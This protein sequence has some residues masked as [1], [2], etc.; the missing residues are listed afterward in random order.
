[1]I[2]VGIQDRKLTERLQLDPELTLAKAI[3]RAWQNETVKKQQP[4]LHRGPSEEP[5][6]NN[7]DAIGLRGKRGQKYQKG[8][9][10]H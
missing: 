9:S 6:V 1:M 7:V 10:S 4:L 2:V 8:Y 3:Q 5:S